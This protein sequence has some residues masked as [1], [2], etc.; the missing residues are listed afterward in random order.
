MHWSAEIE[1]VLPDVSEQPSTR[2]FSIRDYEL[3]HLVGAEGWEEWLPCWE[4]KYL[5]D[6]RPTGLTIPWP[7]AASTGPEL[8]KTAVEI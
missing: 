2:W 1:A 4:R 5:P 6:I 3:Q 7:G 8:G